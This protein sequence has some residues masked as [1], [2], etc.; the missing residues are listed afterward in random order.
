M[1]RVWMGV[2]AIVLAALAA[3]AAFYGGMKLGQK[4]V[5]ND[6]MKYLA[7]GDGAFSIQI[8]EGQFPGGPSGNFRGRGDQFPGTQGTPGAGMVVGG[9]GGFSADTIQAI[10]GNTI[11]LSTADGTVKVITSDTTYIQKYMAATVSDLEVGESVIV[12]G[13]ENDDGSITARSI[14]VMTG[15]GFSEDLATPQP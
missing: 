7:G 11:T 15:L 5:V 3:G 10:D 9:R 2:A 8:G 13:T 12:S 6:P 4:Q 1:K 14:R